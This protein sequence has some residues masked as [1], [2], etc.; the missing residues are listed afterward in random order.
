MNQAII[1]AQELH[2]ASERLSKA[3]QHMRLSAQI[4]SFTFGK[5]ARD[6]KKAMPV[7]TIVIDEAEIQRDSLIPDDLVVSSDIKYPWQ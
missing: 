7:Q 2:D 3:F 1:K 6:A 5:F 4:S